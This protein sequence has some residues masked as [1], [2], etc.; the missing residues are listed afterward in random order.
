MAIHEWVYWILFV[1]WI[2]V[3]LFAIVHVPLFLVLAWSFRA[4]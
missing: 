2:T 1:P 4:W 3:P